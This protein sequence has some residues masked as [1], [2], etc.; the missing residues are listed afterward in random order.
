M[1]ENPIWPV[2][3]SACIVHGCWSD[4]L[5]VC[6]GREQL[7]SQ[8]VLSPAAAHLQTRNSPQHGSTTLLIRNVSYIV[9]QQAPQPAYVET[10]GRAFSR[11]LQKTSLAHVAW[12]FKVQHDSFLQIKD[13]IKPEMIYISFEKLQHSHKIGFIYFRHK[14]CIYCHKRQRKKKTLIHQE[15]VQL[16]IW[17][18]Q[19]YLPNLLPVATRRWEM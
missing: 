3:V 8:S 9:A 5:L 10:K 2:I 19:F 17:S 18:A 12:S 6:V 15:N 4:R 7:D 14:V 16:G 13:A 11:F 1:G